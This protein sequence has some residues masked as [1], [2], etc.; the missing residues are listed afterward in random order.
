MNEWIALVLSLPTE[1]ATVRM[2]AWR[3]LKAAGVAVLRD[4]VYLL[5]YREQCVQLFES[6]KE[7][8]HASGGTAFILNVAGEEAAQFPALFNRTEEFAGLLAELSA[9]HASLSADSLPT[10]IKQLRKLRK[11]FA[12]IAGIDYF[13]GEAQVQVEAALVDT[14]LLLSRLL[15]PDEPSAIDGHVEV[16]DL[17]HYQGR[18]WATRKRPWVD[19]LGSAWLIRTFI[20]ANARIIWLE[21]PDDCPADALGFDFDGA[22][23]SHI[24]NKVTFEVLLTSFALP[25]PALQR[26]AALVH[27]LDV[28]GIQPSEARGL[29]Q[30]LWG[31]RN[32][33]TNDDHLLT[34]ASG[35][36]DALLTAFSEKT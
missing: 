20:D 17:A 12:A 30:I 7:D 31:L 4:G 5:P 24:G 36:F 25:Q 33:I 28:G 8:V 32:T 15:S 22:P 14:E 35:I 3:S 11:T 16:L 19:R 13:P 1:N 21:S 27:Y 9:V 34:T 2:R 10:A 26:F 18:V 23:F 29:E 6:T